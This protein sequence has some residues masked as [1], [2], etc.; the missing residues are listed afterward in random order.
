[1]RRLSVWRIGSGHAGDR[2][3]PTSAPL[4]PPTGPN[5][6]A[7]GTLSKR[8]DRIWTLWSLR[9]VPKASTRAINRHGKLT[10]TRILRGRC[11]SLRC[12]GCAGSELPAGRHPSSQIATSQVPI[13]G[14]LTSNQPRTI[15]P[16]VRLVE[17]FVVDGSG[18]FPAQPE[19]GAAIQMLAYFLDVADVLTSIDLRL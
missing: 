1:M 15:F 18:D 12:R 10:C 13:G 2:S 3:G 17:L 19:A 16:T 6:S 8:C 11:G 7:S 5:E 4:C 14:T 9:Q